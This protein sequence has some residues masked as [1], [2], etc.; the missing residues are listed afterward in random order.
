MMLRKCW[1][2]FL[3]LLAGCN[4]PLDALPTLHVPNETPT[5]VTATPVKREWTESVR[6]LGVVEP[7]SRVVIMPPVDGLLISLTS[8]RQ[9]NATDF[10]EGDP[11]KQGDLLF[12][13]A[14]DRASFAPWILAEG[15]RKQ[16]E[17]RLAE[18]KATGGMGPTAVSQATEVR[19]A[20]RAAQEQLEQLKPQLK[21]V[22]VRAPI[23]GTIGERRLA[24][25]NVVRADD[26]QPLAVIDE[27]DP[28]RISFEIDELVLLRM[29]REGAVIA[30]RSRGQPVRVALADEGLFSHSARV[31]L[32][33]PEV[34][35]TSGRATVRA[36]AEN[37][38]GLLR[39][40]MRVRLELDLAAPRSV[41]CVDTQSIDHDARGS[42]VW[43]VNQ[44]DALEKAYVSPGETLDKV[45]IVQPQPLT[46]G[47]ELTADARYV[48]APPRSLRAEM[49]VRA[50][51][52]DEAPTATEST[53]N[54]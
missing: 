7:N 10:R 2:L 16:A 1:P 9:E 45:R 28:V 34:D 11:V 8:Y 27:V 4:E 29:L 15:Q 54:P 42:F 49:T 48:L 35:S 5:V 17:R 46:G 47:P 14:Q 52:L 33:H 37:P 32:I 39:P 43:V 41:L 12:L 53:T 18:L 6:C 40:G 25:G 13:I 31:D 26:P 23:S 20:G 21:I 51:P 3:M 38:K 22:E 19:A 24:N 44:Q 36:V 30:A 50:R